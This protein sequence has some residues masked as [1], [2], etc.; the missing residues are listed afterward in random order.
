MSSTEAMEM[1]SDWVTQPLDLGSQEAREVYALAGLAL[2]NAQ[3]LEHQII[4]I[5]MVVAEIKTLTKI[6]KQ[7]APHTKEVAKYQSYID[8]LWDETFRKTLGVL[9]KSLR[10]TGVTLPPEIEGDLHRCHDERNRL[11]HRYFRE[12][13]APF[14][15]SAGRR[16][17]AEELTGMLDLFAKT[18]RALEELTKPFQEALGVTDCRAD[19]CVTQLEDAAS[20]DRIA[21]VVAEDAPKNGGE[22]ECLGS[23]E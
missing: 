23:N 22:L 6:R 4:N 12:R 10:E 14:Q 17:M 21:A 8:D 9:I 13:A 16:A 5:L 20:A 19:R 2:Y 3:C 15:T 1:D 7:P 11:V 18:D